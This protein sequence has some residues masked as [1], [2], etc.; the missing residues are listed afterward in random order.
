MRNTH[1]NMQFSTFVDGQNKT[2][3]DAVI[4]LLNADN[5]KRPLPDALRQTFITRDGAVPA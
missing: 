3:G 4:V 5:S 2:K 1:F